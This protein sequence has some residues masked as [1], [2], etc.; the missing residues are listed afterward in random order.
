MKNMIYNDNL[1]GKESLSDVSMLVTQS[2]VDNVG[3][4]CGSVLTGLTKILSG[5]D[6]DVF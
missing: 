3:G 5:D 2:Y 1:L 6:L 4:Y